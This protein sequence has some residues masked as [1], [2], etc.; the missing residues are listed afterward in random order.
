MVEVARADFD[1]SSKDRWTA[2]QRLRFGVE[3]IGGVRKAAKEADVPLSSL[4]RYLNGQSKVPL[5]VLRQVAVA[6]G[7]NPDYLL[8]GMTEG[9][10]TASGDELVQVTLSLPVSAVVSLVRE[11]R[12]TISPE[13]REAIIAA[14]K[15]R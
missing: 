12:A 9:E 8:S 2:Q 7:H 15:E 10:T 1:L 5:N 6:A 4:T 11:V 13:V 3:L 14:L